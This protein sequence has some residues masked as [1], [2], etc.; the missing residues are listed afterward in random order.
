MKKVFSKRKFL[1]EPGNA[2][3][4]EIIK[5]QM[6]GFNWVDKCD[7][8]T[9]EEMH[10]HLYFTHNDWMIEVEES[11]TKKMTR[12]DLQFGDIVTT[13]NEEKYVVADERVYGEIGSYER[14]CDLIEDV[15]DDNLKCSYYEEDE[16]KEFDI[17]K[18][19][20]NGNVIYER[21]ET[22]RELTIKEISELLGYEVKV[23]KEK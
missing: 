12:K 15:Y 21:D 10:E 14:D 1:E 3:F 2:E 9:E 17:M 6:G 4:Y 5:R 23:V 7:G 16:D 22:I 20:R 8:L 11:E 18:V 13:R 19:E